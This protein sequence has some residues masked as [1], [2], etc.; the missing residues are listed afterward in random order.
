MLDKE[1]KEGLEKE[2]SKD[3]NYKKIL[4][5]INKQHASYKT[6]LKIALLPICAVVLTAVIILNLNNKTNEFNSSLAEVN[7]SENTISIQQNTNTIVEIASENKI[8]N[9]IVNEVLDIQIIE[10][11]NEEEKTV[12]EKEKVVDN[13]ETKE[14]NENKLEEREVQ[15]AKG[16]IYKTIEGGESN[17]AYDPTIVE[18][19][20]NDHSE[21]KYVVKVKI[22]SVG[23]GEM[24][25]KQE[26]FN[27]PY[28]CFTP[29]RMQVVD[30]ISNTLS[31]TFTAYITGGKIKIANILKGTEQ[32]IASMGIQDISQLDEE[33]YIEY[34]WS[35]P[36]YEPSVGNEYVMIIN[37]TNPNLYQVFCGGYGI[38]RVEKSSDGTEIYKNVISGKICDF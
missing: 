20:I 35:V 1:V 32:Q 14:N 36:Y 10:E 17:W 38:F 5:N 7:I 9:E 16:T 37:K 2:F 34:K 11:K 25:P 21:N 13:T 18:N 8:N 29:I 33:Q 15:V 3:R 4:N 26:K 27:N 24:L 6:I 12:E 28:T 22:L 30:N 31:G 23:E 19:L